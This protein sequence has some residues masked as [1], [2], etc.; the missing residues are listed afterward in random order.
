M[1]Q[2]KNAEYVNF[3]KVQL[4]LLISS[5]KKFIAEQ[6]DTITSLTDPTNVLSLSFKMYSGKSAQVVQV[7]ITVWLLHLSTS[8]VERSTLTKIKESIFEVS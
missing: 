4:T 2:C 5:S 3:I 7:N 6:Q 1:D 8:S